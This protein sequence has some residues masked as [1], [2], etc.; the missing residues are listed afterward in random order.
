MRSNNIHTLQ[1]VEQNRLAAIQEANANFMAT[2][3]TLDADLAFMAEVADN[4]VIFDVVAQ[5]ATPIPNAPLPISQINSISN[6]IQDTSLNPI[7]DTMPTMTAYQRFELFQQVQQRQQQLRADL[8]NNMPAQAEPL[9]AS[10]RL[11][12]LNQ[13]IQNL[14]EQT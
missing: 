11:A 4:R 2:N 9:S 8:P 14:G 12:N 7:A 5:N 13:D 1:T 6:T 10:E 3:N